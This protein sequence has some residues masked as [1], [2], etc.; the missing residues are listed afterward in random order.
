MSL[1][2]LLADR[3]LVVVTGK[4]GV[5]KSLTSA[6]LGRLIAGRGR[7][8]LLMEVD[9]RESLHELAGVAP[10][11]GDVLEVAAGL[12]LQ[13]LQPVHV[14]EAVVREHLKLDVLVR[15]VTGSPVFTHF[16]DAAPG[17]KELAVLGHA[18]RLARGLTRFPGGPPDVVV[19]DAPATGHGVSLLGAPS[20]AAHVITDGPFAHMASELAAFIGAPSETA[21][22]VVTLAEEMPV[23]EALELRDALGRSLARVPDLL[24]INA[25][26]PP[27]EREAAAGLGPVL[28][29][30]WRE[31][32]AINE[33][34]LARLERAWMGP[35]ARLP[36]VAVP[37]GPSLVAA[38]V[39]ALSEAVGHD[40]RSS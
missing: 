22:V 19:L 21:I 15:R 9:P 26:F 2:D 35:R 25:L 28:A 6:A 8:V 27:F 12:R 40:G 23:Q 1:L 4:G 20:A 16:V 7:R 18:Y 38:I 14:L 31:R 39:P 11:G 24:V 36:L 3:R 32:R 10:S 5:G 33:R 30:L 34:E 17:L 29:D 13:N 37:R